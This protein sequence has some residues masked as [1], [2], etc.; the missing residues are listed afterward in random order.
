MK[1]C[2]VENVIILDLLKA[3]NVKT[4][5]GVLSFLLV[6]SLHSQTYTYS[7]NEL[8]PTGSQ[9][10]GT[11]SE[12]NSFPTNVYNYISIGRL[13]AGNNPIERSVS[14]VGDGSAGCS[15][16]D[17]ALDGSNSS[18]D[19]GWPNSA[20]LPEGSSIKLTNN[21]PSLSVFIKYWEDV[22]GIF[23]YPFSC[24]GTGTADLILA[25]RESV[26]LMKS[27]NQMVIVPPADPV[28]SLGQ[29]SLIILGI[30][31]LIFSTVARSQRATFKY[32]H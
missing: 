10:V 24:D 9:W 7:F 23:N 22:A 1:S 27:G 26:T 6:L 31:L 32:S 25:P 21:H 4:I 13:D 28:P 29:W 2:Y 20:S 30:L 5:F 3:S 18:S 17:D 11:Y 15:I 8:P 19:G 12:S 14:L 16:I